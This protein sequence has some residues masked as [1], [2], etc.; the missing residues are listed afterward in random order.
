MTRVGRAE[1]EGL[2]A[3]CFTGL[4]LPARDAAAVARVLVYADLRGLA[5]H[6]VYRVPA[7]LERVVRGLA[8]G[9]PD[10][11][12]TSGSGAVRRVDAAHALGPAVA[13]RAT[14]LAIE[15]GREFGIGLVAV[16]R[17][18]HFGAA[19]Y[20]VRR[21]AEQ[22]LVG[23]VTSN[24][25]R[26]V[27]P[28]GAAEPFLG[29]NPLAVGVPLG[30]HGAFVHDMATGASRAKIRR[31]AD[32]G[33]AIEHGL[34]LDADG[35]PTTDAAAALLGSVLPVGGAQGSGLALAVALLAG[36]VAG[37]EFDDEIAP[38]YGALDRPQDLGQLVVV[39]DPASLGL[40]VD[41]TRRRTEGFVDRLHGLRPRPGQ[42]V[43]FSGE[44]AAERAA[45]AEAE[46]V[47]V[48]AAELERIAAACE[49]HGLPAPAAR[50]RELARP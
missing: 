39:L 34:A 46:G 18:T 2:V 43:R 1:L 12:P 8:G 47:E 50:A 24:G 35:L 40:D 4:G 16:H 28:H 22:G 23:V 37:A 6:G 15:L 31:A 17:S 10:E 3:D 42:S 45:R 36:A 13:E 38:T 44:A 30:R 49:A 48:A 26:V 32:A 7:Y 27:A 21:V 29:T 41:D 11:L 14:D 19:G 33:A 9:T 25:P 20:Y 5:A